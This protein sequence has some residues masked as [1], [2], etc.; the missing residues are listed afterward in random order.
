MHGA[1]L[2]PYGVFLVRVGILLQLRCIY[3]AVW[4]TVKIRF[5]TLRTTPIYACNRQVRAV[6]NEPIFFKKVQSSKYFEP[7]RRRSSKCFPNIW[8]EVGP[9]NVRRVASKFWSL[10]R[11]FPSTH[12]RTA[13]AEPRASLTTRS[14]LR[15]WLGHGRP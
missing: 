6:L 3:G 11:P 10:F 13:A 2:C 8:N 15:S 4:V 9:E 14:Q 5:R 12:V 1:G 7:V